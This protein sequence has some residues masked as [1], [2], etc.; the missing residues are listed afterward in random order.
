MKLVGKA[1]RV[2]IYV[3]E[4]DKVGWKPAHLAVLELLRREN[5]Q[6]ATV[7]RGLEGFG[8]AG[9]IHVSHL[10]DVAQDLPLVVEWIDAPEVVERLIGRVKE[11]VPRGLITVDDT[12]IVLYEPHPVRDLSAALTA[13]DVMSR[14]VTSVARSTP[15][16]EVVELMLGKVY[17]AVPVVDGGAPVG[18]ITSTDL[19]QKGGLG[20]R[21]ELLESL[22]KPDVHEVLERLASTGKAAAEVM[23]PAPVTV[24]ARTSLP[25]IA[26]IMTHRRLKRLPVVDERGALVGMVSRLDLLRTAAGGLER[27]EP[28]VGEMGLRGNVPLSRVMRRDVPTVQ[29]DTPLPEVFQAVV[30]TRLNRALVVDAERRVVGLVTDAEMLERLTPSL[31]PG[32]LRSLVHRLPFAHPS[33]DERAAEQHARARRAADLM[34]TDVAM[35]AEETL[36]SDAIGLMLRGKHKV[37][38][39]TDAAGRLVGMVDRADL[40]HGLWP[41][42]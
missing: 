22:D 3:N 9:H 2:R 33:A 10:V 39:V 23:T 35:A 14:Q 34:S 32:A 4:G 11:M 1:R 21:V 17:R 5:A 38:A 24:E 30:S 19:V 8:A 16:R 25:R 41:H 31:R 12:E 28:V 7:L 29:P 6:G 26:E 13:A 27:A 42:E 40:L 36:L 37:L 20:M 18:I 15:V